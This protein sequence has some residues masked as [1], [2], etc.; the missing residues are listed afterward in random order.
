MKFI[1][2]GCLF[3]FLSGNLLSQKLWTEED[4]KYLLNKLITTRDSLVTETENLSDTQWNFREAPGRWTIKEV[5]EHIAIWEL[6]LMH[7]VSKGLGAGPQPQWTSK[8][9]SVYV[10]FILEEKPHISVEYTKPF[11]YTLP[12]GLNTGKNNLAWFLKMRNESIGYIKTA[13]ED[14]RMY[15]LKQTRPNVHQVYITIFGH[16][17]RHLRQIRK[18]KANAGYPKG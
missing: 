11:T 9:D 10:N 1:L 4:R 12:L 5:T 14:L 7:E 8:P 3:L 15:Y 13:E 17:Q 2:T 6:L 18:I 16:C